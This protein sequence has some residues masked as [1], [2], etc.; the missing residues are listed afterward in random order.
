MPD[1][2]SSIISQICKEDIHI[3]GVNRKA[4]NVSSIITQIFKEDIHIDGVNRKA[5][6]GEH[7]EKPDCVSEEV[8]EKWLA[9]RSLPEV[10]EKS[11]RNWYSEKAGLD[12]GCSR[13]SGGFRSAMSM[14]LLW[15]MPYNVSSIITHILKEDIQ[16]DGV[17]WKGEP[18]LHSEKYF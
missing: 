4:D 1:N 17:H 11:P 9:Y 2:V 16:K 3:D 8:W 15:L 14:L 13:H 5:V 12:T 18:G 10:I 6:A 7:K